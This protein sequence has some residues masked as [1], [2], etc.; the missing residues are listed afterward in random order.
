MKDLHD[1]TF[2]S[3]KKETEEDIR[4]WK[5]RPCPWIGRI[6]IVKMAVLLKAIY[7]FNVIPIK[8]QHK[9]LQTLKE[10]FPTSYGKTRNP[11]IA[12]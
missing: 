3:L 6:N 5:D 11:R 4:R 7:R 2:K 10:Q 1:K 12:N 8:F 9:S